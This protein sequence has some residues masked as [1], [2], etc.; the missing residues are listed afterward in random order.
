MPLSVMLRVIILS[1]IMTRDIMF[2]VIM[3][4][5]IAPIPL[6]SISYENNQNDRND[7]MG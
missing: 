5:V 2:S 7:Q 4:V 3:L 1:V 6:Y